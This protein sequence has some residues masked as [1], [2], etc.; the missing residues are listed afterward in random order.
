M[1]RPALWIELDG[2]PMLEMARSAV[3]AKPAEVVRR[4]IA[5][6]RPG[7][8]RRPGRAAAVAALAALATLTA[9]TAAAPAPALAAG[10]AP[11]APGASAT[12]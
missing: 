7:A 3:N 6:S 11:G 2:K 1:A 8:A 10:A 5:I 4:N 9:L 12:C